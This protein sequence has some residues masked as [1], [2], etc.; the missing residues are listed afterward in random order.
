[1]LHIV[2]SSIRR[3]G[4]PSGRA[5]SIPKRTNRHFHSVANKG[6]EREPVLCAVRAYLPDPGDA[7]SDDTF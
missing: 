4:I 2:S 6:Y 3:L 7:A 1:M 5:E